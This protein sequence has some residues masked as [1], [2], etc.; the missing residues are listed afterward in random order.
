MAKKNK[1]VKKGLK[2]NVE[3]NKETKTAQVNNATETAEKKQETAEKK[4]EEVVTPPVQEQET[5]EQK[6]D[7][8]PKKEAKKK[9]AVVIPEV[10]EE[11]KETK[12]SKA[13]ANI[14]IGSTGSSFDAKAMLAFTMND[15]YA[16]NKELSEHYPE[17]YQSMNRNIDVVVVLSLIDL[18][19]ELASKNER[20]E[21]K[22]TISPDQVIQL[23]EAAAMLG[24]TLAPTKEL[25]SKDSKDT[26]LS[27]DFTES[28]IPESLQ[29]KKEEH[30]E[31][32]ELDPKKIT[33]DE[34]V[35]AALSHLLSTGKNIVENI[36]NTVEW[37]RV[38]SITKEENAEK[39]LSLDDRSVGEWLGEIFSKVPTTCI[40]NGFGS[41]MYNYTVTEG[42]P[43]H[44]HS[45][46]HSYASRAGWSED[47]V[48]DLIK[49]FI[50]GKYNLKVKEGTTQDNPK[51]NKAIVA[52]VGDL[53]LDFVNKLFEDLNSEDPI[54]KAQA[55]KT[56]EC[57]RNH[58]FKKEDKV[59]LDALRLKVGQI[60]NLYRDPMNR[61]EESA[62]MSVEETEKKKS[63]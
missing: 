10:V 44:A 53:G 61:I 31:K 19:N 27:L 7:K 28:K 57:V 43:L 25:P 20:G 11:N 38:Y 58:Y 29:E 51:E 45:I 22:L 39:K 47:Q 34:Q 14:P 40:F 63:E 15:R 13:L 37:Y 35:A 32:V 26:Q 49:C 42:N 3:N 52:I 17:F 18:R 16:H 50:T 41:A 30:T 55:K 33:T 12:D 60:I 5:K 2:T 4:Q 1:E 6:E 62:F 9:P 56:V 54:V 48:A 8:Q 36:I 24:I 21:I 59:D 23:N 46:T